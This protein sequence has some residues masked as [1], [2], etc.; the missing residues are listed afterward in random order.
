MNSKLRHQLSSQ[1]A[2][3]GHGRGRFMKG[4]SPRTPHYTSMAQA[5]SLVAEIS[6]NP[7]P[8]GFAISFIFEY[9]PSGKVTSV[10]RSAT[11]FRRELGP[12]VVIVVVWTNDDK[13]SVDKARG[14]ANAIAGILVSTNQE[15][16][17]KSVGYANYG[18]SVLLIAPVAGKVMSPRTFRYGRGYSWCFK[19]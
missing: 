8:E 2:F 6:K 10:P 18:A 4:V 7:T 5:Q 13:D 16:N 9:I 17:E 19:G 14:Y 1:N 12:N 11:A 3:S 15:D